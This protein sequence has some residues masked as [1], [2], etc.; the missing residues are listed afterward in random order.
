MNAKNWKHRILTYSRIVSELNHCLHELAPCSAVL[1]VQNYPPAETL[2]L[3]AARIIAI[4]A[5]S[6]SKLNL[7]KS[8]KKFVTEEKLNMKRCYW[9]YVIGDGH[10]LLYQNCIHVKKCNDV[11]TFVN[12]DF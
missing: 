12:E 3:A 7:P 8:L 5:E 10:Y 2:A 1:G 6:I 9:C 4:R 11:C